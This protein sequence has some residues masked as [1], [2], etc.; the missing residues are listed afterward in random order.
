MTTVGELWLRLN[1]DERNRVGAALTTVLPGTGMELYMAI[2]RTAHRPEPQPA[3]WSPHLFAATPE[4]A[5]PVRCHD[6]D[7]EVSVDPI[8]YV[9]EDGKTIVQL[10]GGCWRKRMLRTAEDVSARHEALTL[11]IDQ[12]GGE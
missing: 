6:C 5:K 3:D 12:R 9:L 7:T 11:P 10:G 1:N 8:A 2:M 4:P